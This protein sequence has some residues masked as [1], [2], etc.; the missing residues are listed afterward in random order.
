MLNVMQCQT[1]NLDIRPS[2]FHLLANDD[3][4]LDHLGYVNSCINLDFLRYLSLS[5]LPL[6]SPE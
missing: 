1:L 5:D 2:K 6:L 3:D 4:T